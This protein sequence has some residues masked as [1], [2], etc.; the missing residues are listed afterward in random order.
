MNGPFWR[1]PLHWLLNLTKPESDNSAGWGPFR[2]PEDAQW[3]QLAANAH[4]FDYARSDVAPDEKRRSEADFDLFWRWALFAHGQE[5][6]IQR[7]KMAKQI[8]EYW[9]L[10]RTAGVYLWGKR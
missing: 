6:P 5:D 10:A 8:C 1:N 4:D 9:P 2:L 7:C 3:M